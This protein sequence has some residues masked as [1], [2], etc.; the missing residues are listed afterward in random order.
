[1]T[2][3]TG[4]TVKELA[5]TMDVGVIGIGGFATKLIERIKEHPNLRI[6]FGYH[7]NREKAAHWDPEL[8]TSSLADLLNAKSLEAIFVLTPTHLHFEYCA[9]VIGARKHVFVEKPLTHTLEDTRKLLGLLKDTP[10]KLMV[11]HNLRRQPWSREI[12]RIIRSGQLGHIVNVT[13]NKSHGAI[14]DLPDTSWRKNILFHPEGPL[15]TVGI[16]YFDLLHDWFGSI[17]FVDTILSCAANRSTAPDAN[18]VMMGLSGGTTVFLQTNYCLCS[19]DYVHIYGT[20]G[21]LY[22]ERNCLSLRLGRDTDRVP[23]QSR[24]IPLKTDQ[25]LAEEIDEFYQSIT[26]KRRIVTGPLEGLNNM[27]VLDACQISHQQ[28]RR[29]FLKEYVDYFK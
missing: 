12:K 24:G 16:H 15:A 21:T 23:T 29:V 1:M 17:E 19:E 8:G 28:K 4:S 10:L 9:Q 22:Y 3:V 20:E 11:G 18:A 14:F 5:C 25:S 27:I 13:I 7:P 2:V 26:A 6:R